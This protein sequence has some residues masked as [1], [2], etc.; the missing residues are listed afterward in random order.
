MEAIE[1]V[2]ETA[3]WEV[4]GVD[5][6]AAAVGVVPTGQPIAELD[7]ELGERALRVNTTV[8]ARLF[9]AV[10]P[11][12]ARGPRGARLVLVST[13][14]VAVPG[15]GVAAYSTSKAGAAQLARVA[16]LEWA[17]DGIQVNQV[18]PDAVF[19]TAIWTPELLRERAARCGFTVE[20]HRAR[21]VLRSAPRCA[22]PQ[23]QSPRSAR[24]SP[25]PPMPASPGSV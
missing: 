5:L 15:P 16:A 17:A 14:N 4:S 24:V 9:R 13:K 6:L 1:A 21:N 11:F 20:E 18:E 8:L 7:D 3:A 25:R 10:H 22:A 12:L 23:W 2:T 19:D